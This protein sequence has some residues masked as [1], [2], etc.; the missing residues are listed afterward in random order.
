MHILKTSYQGNPNIGLFGWA[1]DKVCLVGHGFKDK[2]VSKIKKVLDVPIHKVSLCN[3]DLIGV[4]CIGNNEA[5]VIPDTA[6]DH[7][8]KELKEICK[9]Y[10][11]ALEIVSTTL[12]ALGNNICC[13]DLGALVNP[14]YSAS[15]KKQL[16]QVLR[17][18]LKPGTIALHGIPGSL[19]VLRG[20][21]AIV[22]SNILEKEEDKLKELF[23]V[24]KITHAT[25]NFGSPN[26]G[27][28]ILCNKNGFVV[29]D[30]SSG[31]EMTGIDE[32]LGFIDF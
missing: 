14:D 16:R 21:Y 32:G 9:K 27:A 11:M 20:D 6:L 29:G 8:I 30:M 5:L 4:F 31:V 19:C 23:G 1:N 2:V 7:E 28:G 22:S 24:D 13:N 18:N 3:T 25:V 12:N 10:D 15:V 26:L 17:V